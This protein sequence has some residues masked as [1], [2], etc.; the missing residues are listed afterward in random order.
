MAENFRD[1]LTEHFNRFELA[2]S[3]D[4]WADAFEDWLESLDAEDFIRLGEE[5]G[6]TLKQGGHKN[7]R[8][9]PM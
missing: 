2:P 9:I 1:Y 3:D 5:Y 7:V 4:A 8:S 6:R